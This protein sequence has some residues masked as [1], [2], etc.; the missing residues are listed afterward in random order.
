M[1]CLWRHCDHTEQEKET[2]ARNRKRLSLSKKGLGAGME[3]REVGRG[4]GT[5]EQITEVVLACCLILQGKMCIRIP[6][7]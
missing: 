7:S 4:G 5:K 1:W 3:N 2:E 6:W